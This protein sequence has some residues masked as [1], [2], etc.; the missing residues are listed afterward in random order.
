MDILP[1]IRRAAERCPLP[2]YD[3]NTLQ[4]AEFG[5]GSGT[6]SMAAVTEMIPILENRFSKSQTTKHR[7]HPSIPQPYFVVSHTDMPHTDFSPLFKLLSKPSKSYLAYSPLPMHEHWRKQKTSRR[8]RDYAPRT[9]P[10]QPRQSH[11]WT[12]ELGERPA[13]AV[14]TKM[15]TKAARRSANYSTEEMQQMQHPSFTD[16]RNVE[17]MMEAPS[18]PAMMSKASQQRPHTQNFQTPAILEEPEEENL[19][20]EE[21]ARVS[22][23]ED[24]LGLSEK[25]PSPSKKEQLR[26]STSAQSRN[27]SSALRE[28]QPVIRTNVFPHIIG[29]SIIRRLFPDQSIHL[30]FSIYSLHFLSSPPPISLSGSIYSFSPR[31]SAVE[32]LSFERRAHDDLLTFLYLR[33]AEFAPG[34][35]LVLSFPAANEN[36]TACELM[37]E[38]LDQTLQELV[39]ETKLTRS[40][41][42]ALTQPVHC[43]TLR[44]TKEVLLSVSHL[45][46]VR[47]FFVVH[48]PQPAWAVFERGQL[49]DKEYAVAC[50]RGWE[51]ATRPGFAQSLKREGAADVEGL[52]D[53]I[54]SRWS[55][56]LLQ[57]AQE[58]NPLVQP[59]ICLRLESVGARE[60]TCGCGRRRSWWCR[61]IDRCQNAGFQR[62]P[63]PTAASQTK[64][65]FFRSPEPNPAMIG[66]VPA[67]RYVWERSDDGANQP[68]P[69]PKSWHL[70]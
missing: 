19:T 49:T 14:S 6:N 31:V 26:H 53:E 63:P 10:K 24:V 59:V 64:I 20:T 35:Q 51:A 42:S 40:Q 45:W 15:A 57:V 43:R 60:E 44:E 58:P 37:V 12:P 23:D 62:Q 28:L 22:S 21:L 69:R 65:S 68:Y 66:G 32:R 5:C 47:E 2:R 16:A 54:Y 17:G 27:G 29:Q 55:H 30:G 52:I 34:G 39:E 41:L 48:Q 3:E 11:E 7:K 4:I 9:P 38:S 36:G 8:S 18:Y 70:L 67:G 46:R 50:V 33:A 1:V 13:S 25:Q 61:L 56:K